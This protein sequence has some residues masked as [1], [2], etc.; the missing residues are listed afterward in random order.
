M[1][2]VSVIS[3]SDDTESPMGRMMPSSFSGIGPPVT[4]RTRSKR[5][6]RSRAP[7][8]LIPTPRS[9][10]SKRTYAQRSNRSPSRRR[11]NHNNKNKILSKSTSKKR[12]RQEPNLED[13]F[14]RKP[15]KRR[16]VEKIDC[17]SD[18][19]YLPYV[20]DKID[21]I[22]KTK[23]MKKYSSNKRRRSTRIQNQNKSKTAPKDVPLIDLSNE[24]NEEDDDIHSN[25][26]N[27]NNKMS[28]D[29]DSNNENDEIELVWGD[30]QMINHTVAK[31]PTDSIPIDVEDD[32]DEDMDIDL[33]DIELQCIG[34]AIG[35]HTDFWSTRD[36]DIA[37]KIILNKHQNSIDL[38][39]KSI[40]GDCVNVSI[41]TKDIKSLYIP[42]NPSLHAMHDL[43]LSNKLK[44]CGDTR[45]DPYIQCIF[46]QTTDKL[47][48][49]QWLSPF[50]DPNNANSAG[51]ERISLF[52]GHSNY[53]KFK[54][55]V[56]NKMYFCEL[57]NAVKHI[58]LSMYKQFCI[59]LHTT[60]IL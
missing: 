20:D 34:I 35:K 22:L 46:I 50:Y 52:I 37:P 1:R 60:Q 59:S 7:L 42:H 28:V 6:R 16:I 24:Q 43:K 40:H 58:E 4:S 23:P 39:L 29:G 56:M 30:I 51:I 11:R 55:I 19:E 36:T 31:Q 18:D 21:E 27:T 5:K 17:D 53:C 33:N 15:Q 47:S 3:I 54:K 57:R 12:K 9:F 14:N 32:D 26:S 13:S 25:S 49:Y 41:H 38:H 48:P 8:P 45:I 44:E 10:S 2:S